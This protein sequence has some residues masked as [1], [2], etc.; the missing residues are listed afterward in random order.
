MGIN[1]DLK[2]GHIKTMLKKGSS[3]LFLFK[4]KYWGVIASELCAN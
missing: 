4:L 3:L 1:E 2:Q